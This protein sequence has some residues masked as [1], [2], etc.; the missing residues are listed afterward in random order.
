MS[1]TNI[2]NCDPLYIY[3]GAGVRND[4]GTHY[5]IAQNSASLRDWA[6]EAA[7][8]IHSRYD[9]VESL[10]CLCYRGFSGVALA[11][12]VSLAYS[13]KYDRQLNLLYVRKGKESPHGCPIE[14]NFDENEVEIETCI[15]VDDFIDGGGTFC[16]VKASTEGCL[17]KKDWIAICQRLWRVG[18]PPLWPEALDYEK[19]VYFPE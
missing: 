7:E 1:F 14:M 5:S 16:Q 3:A 11:T 13:F 4:M 9:G 6:W 12:A 18:S 15:F 19:M 2:K 8:F 17:G 10:L